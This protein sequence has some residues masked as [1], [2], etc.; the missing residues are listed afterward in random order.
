MRIWTFAGAA[1]LLAALAVSGCASSPENSTQR[2]AADGCIIVS[3]AG[4]SPVSACP[5]RLVLNRNFLGLLT[6]YCKMRLTV[7]P[8]GTVAEARKLAGGQRLGTYCRE[9][10]YRWRFDVSGTG[11]KPVE[12]NVRIQTAVTFDRVVGGGGHPEEYPIRSR[13]IF[14][15]VAIDSL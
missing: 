3:S 6:E 12:R 1:S 15:P 5:E 13:I 11:G 9:S 7:R 4:K 14:D 10:M 8:D 2:V